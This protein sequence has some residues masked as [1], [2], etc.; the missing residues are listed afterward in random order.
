MNKEETYQRLKRELLDELDERF[1][2]D[3]LENN[4]GLIKNIADEIIGKS[5]LIAKKEISKNE[6]TKLIT[7]N[8]NELIRE[9]VDETLKMDKILKEK[10]KEIVKDILKEIE[11]FIKINIVSAMNL[12]FDKFKGVNLE[13]KM[14]E[15]ARDKLL[16]LVSVSDLETISKVRKEYREEAEKI[17]KEILVELTDDLREIKR[18]RK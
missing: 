10:E 16:E 3:R 17:K 9:R 18:K 4:Q 11:E 2:K 14:V 1:F 5:E 8:L 7:S 6:I 13:R 15:Y 12:A